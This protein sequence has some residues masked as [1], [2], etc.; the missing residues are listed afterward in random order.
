MTAMV[1]FLLWGEDMSPLFTD[2]TYS[3][4]RRLGYGCL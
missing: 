4:G 3:Q 2:L 1:E